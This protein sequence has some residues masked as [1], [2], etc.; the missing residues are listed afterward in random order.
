MWHLRNTE[1]RVL[2]NVYKVPEELERA[3]AV[4]IQSIITF[5]LQRGMN[6]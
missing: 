6:M 4:G 3:G 5:I 1:V 2:I